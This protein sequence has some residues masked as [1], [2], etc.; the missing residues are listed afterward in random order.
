MGVEVSR[1]ENA[2]I[3]VTSSYSFTLN[4]NSLLGQTKRLTI[5]SAA[6]H[7]MKD[8]TVEITTFT[9]L[10]NSFRYSGAPLRPKAAGAKHH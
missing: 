6:L 9:T 3:T 7:V 1:G 4:E 5:T 8:A 2:G 10:N